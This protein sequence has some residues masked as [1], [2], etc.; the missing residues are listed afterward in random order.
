MPPPRAASPQSK[1]EIIVVL[2]YSEKAD[3]GRRPR[4]PIRRP[5]KLAAFFLVLLILPVRAA[6]AESSC[7]PE[8]TALNVYETLD[9]NS[10][11]DFRHALKSQ[12][13]RGIYVTNVF[14][15]AKQEHRSLALK[16]HFREDF[17]GVSLPYNAYALMVLIDGVPAYYQDFTEGCVG[18]GLGFYPGQIIELKAIPI[19]PS[20]GAGSARVQI[21]VWGRI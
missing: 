8:F 1:V 7:W 19:D 9:L 13:A 3:S 5:M 15:S 6:A 20:A 21:L 2:F 10:S 14:L 16:F 4:S 11:K 12:N 18:P 17:D